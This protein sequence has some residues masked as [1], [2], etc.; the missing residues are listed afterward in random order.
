M[1]LTDNDNKEMDEIF[2]NDDEDEPPSALPPLTTDEAGAPVAVDEVD[3]EQE[4]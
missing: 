1:Q 2:L 3:A 4:E